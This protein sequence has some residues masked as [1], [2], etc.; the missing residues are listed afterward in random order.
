MSLADLNSRLAADMDQSNIPSEQSYEQFVQ[1]F[2]RHE[3]GLRWFLRSL[4][5]TWE[6]ADE[7]MQ[8][9][10][11]VLW[12]KFD[13]FEPGTDFGRWSCT[14]ARFEVLKFRRKMARDRLVF[15]EGLIGRLADEAIEESPRAERERQALGRCLEK[16]QSR[17]RELVCAF[18]SG[19]KIKDIAEQTGR[20]AT[21]LYKALRRIR[22]ALLQCIVSTLE[23][24][25]VHE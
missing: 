22:E 20:T 4:L 7:V 16:L 23:E 9:T 12:R 21:A 8:Q 13:D 25:P 1:L 15:D 2:A 3:P 19:K 18:Y 11:L 6:H 10:C 17:Q 14:V 5:P 24:D